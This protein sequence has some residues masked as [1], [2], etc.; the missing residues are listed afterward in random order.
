MTPVL[1]FDIETI[2]DVAGIRRLHDLPA[3]LTDPEVAEVAFQRRR[4]QTGSDFLPPQ[5]QRVAVISCVLRNDEGIQ[6]F[7]IG[8]PER[9]EPEILQKFFDGVEKLVPQLVS[10]NG[11]GFD[12]PVLNYRSLIHKVSAPAF[13]DTGDENRDFR[14]NNYLSRYHSRHLDLMDVLAMYQPRNNAP[15]DDVAQ[16]SGLPGKIGIGGAKVW[17][18]WLA[19]EVAKIRDYCEADTANTYLLYLRYQLLRGFFSREAYDKET[20]L[21]RSTLESIDKPHWREFL[22]LWNDS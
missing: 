2:P 5:L 3:D 11:G 21:L 15:L 13:W 10:W 1:A 19:G 20:R 12:L 14:Y 7:S 9:K 6:V 17:E 4:T 16:L 8:E 22:Q 18:T